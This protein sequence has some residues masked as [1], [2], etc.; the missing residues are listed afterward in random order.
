[1]SR[2]TLQELFVKKQPEQIMSPKE[3]DAIKSALLYPFLLS[4]NRLL[5]TIKIDPSHQ[6]YVNAAAQSLYVLALA[7]AS[8]LP[9]G[10]SFPT[11]E[12]SDFL[13]FCF[14]V[15]E[16]FST[17]ADAYSAQEVDY[18]IWFNVG[19]D[20]EKNQYFLCADDH[21]DQNNPL[22]DYSV[23]PPI[24]EFSFYLNHSELD[25]NRI[26]GGKL[27]I[28]DETGKPIEYSFGQSK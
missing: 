11:Q 26:V 17:E 25:P 19:H 8:E 3:R 16:R 22:P 7:K 27:R 24:T 2:E 12:K 10:I 23:L 15:Y 14:I 21:R 1:M 28:S 9:I 4:M 13:P 18:H 6:S 20:P 5:T